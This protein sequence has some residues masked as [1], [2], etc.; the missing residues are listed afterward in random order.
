MPG[1]HQF[2]A[3]A[4]LCRINVCFCVVIVFALQGCSKNES[5]QDKNNN[6]GSNSSNT[7]SDVSTDELIKQVISKYTSAGTYADDGKLTLSYSLEGQPFKEYYS[8]GITY[9]KPLMLKA[10]FFNTRVVANSRRLISFVF[11]SD[12]FN[13]DGQHIILPVEHSIPISDLLSDSIWSHYSCGASEL[14]I[15][16]ADDMHIRLLSPILQFFS[17]VECASWLTSGET[18]WQINQSQ[19]IKGQDCWEL[20]ASCD[21]QNYTVWIDKTKLLIRAIQI[22]PTVLA[23][24]GG[25]DKSLNKLKILFEFDEATW[26][27]D[28]LPGHFDF[29][30]EATWKPV[31]KFIPVPEKFPTRLIGEHR[32]S[33]TFKQ[34]NGQTWSPENR[35]AISAVII[36]CTGQPSKLIVEKIN[37]IAGK[38]NK[39]DFVVAITTP[40]FQ[41]DSIALKNRINSFAVLDANAEIARRFG[42]EAFPSMAIIGPFGKIQYAQAPLEHDWLERIAATL[43]RLENG[44]DV[45]SEMK[46]SYGVFLTKYQEQIKQERN[47]IGQLAE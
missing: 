15:D 41:P 12:T 39:T 28:I 6:T 31:R 33:F 7:A 24:V 3:K 42:I 22:P 14:P 2:P 5:S 34:M 17:D 27:P 11:D 16:A 13:L 21:N 40:D 4:N 25:A 35:D 37:E 43:V 47:A 44:E 26:N 38:I 18:Q 23:G 9:K 46:Q 8:C 29:H 32:P 1:C 10:S 36:W 19:T 45:A 20:V 30:A